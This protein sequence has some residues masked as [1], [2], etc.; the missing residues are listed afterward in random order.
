MVVLIA[1]CLWSI[2]CASAN[3]GEALAVIAPTTLPQSMVMT[4]LSRSCNRDPENEAQ[5]KSH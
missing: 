1:T 5:V 4:L 2:N 3:V